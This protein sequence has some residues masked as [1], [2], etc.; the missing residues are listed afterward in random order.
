MASF[1]QRLLAEGIRTIEDDTPKLSLDRPANQS[2]SFEKQLLQRALSIDN[3]LGISALLLHFKHATRTLFVLASLLFMVIG[4][5]T[6]QNVFFIEDDAQINFFWAFALFFIPNIISLLLWLVFF[7]PRPRSHYNWLVRISQFLLQ[8]SDKLINKVFVKNAHYRP[9]FAYHFRL[10]FTG[11]LGRFQLSYFSHLLWFSYFSGAVLMLLSILATHQVDFIWQTSILSAQRFQWLTELLAYLPN[12]L[13]FPVPSLTQIQQSNITNFNLINDAENTRLVW[14]SLLISSLLV[15]GLLPRLILM[16]L[17]QLLLIFK[18][19]KFRLNFSLPYYVQLRQYLK[20]NFT[21]LG[22]VDSDTDKH[23]I[24]PTTINETTFHV[25]PSRIYPVA[26]ELSTGQLKHVKS[27]I[28]NGDAKQVTLLQHVVDFDSQQKLLNSLTTVKEP[29]IAIYVALQRLPDRGVLSFIKSL[30]IDST[31]D[32]YLLLV[33][34]ERQVNLN[35]INKRRSDWYSLAAQ[36][37]IPLDNIT[38]LNIAD[39]TNN[40]S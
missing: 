40:G 22:I 15:Y 25:L 13:G 7:L 24:S 26:V 10:F 3:K 34:D 6:V 37:N 17:M 11:E 33:N 27:H 36:A 14:S 9:L 39:G 21:S 5:T 20:P 29:A 12:L 32:Y 23:E 30:T 28:N 1:E 38:Q 31:K 8:Q 2:S 4:A 19:N 35:H 16:L 18:K